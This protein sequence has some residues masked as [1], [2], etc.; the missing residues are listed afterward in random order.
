MEGVELYDHRG[1]RGNDFNA[2]EN[3]N[4]AHD[5]TYASEVQLLAA[6]LRTSFN[7]PPALA[8]HMQ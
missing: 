8:V 6:Q 2:W 3:A 1:D 7:E 5:P 4:L